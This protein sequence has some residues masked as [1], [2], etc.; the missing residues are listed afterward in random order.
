MV[1]FKEGEIVHAR[2]LDLRNKEA[3]F[4]LVGVKSG[5][6]IYT[7]GIPKELDKAPPIGGFIG[8]IMEGLQRIDEN[9]A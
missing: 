9:K 3:V 6:F 1:F 8:I 7:K 2:F 4:A 5:H